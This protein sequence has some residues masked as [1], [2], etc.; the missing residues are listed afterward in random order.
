MT[1][2]NVYAEVLGLAV[3]AAQERADMAA[4]QQLL[5]LQYEQLHQLLGPEHP[6]T[7]AARLP[8]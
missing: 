1:L 8:E 4:A 2:S 7:L 5:R 6:R 3:L